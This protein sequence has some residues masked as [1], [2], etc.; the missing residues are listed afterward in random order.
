MFYVN[1]TGKS[2]RQ[3]EL[4]VFGLYAKKDGFW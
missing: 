3:S 4:E 2:L 1:W